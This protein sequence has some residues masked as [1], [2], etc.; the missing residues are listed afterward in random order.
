MFGQDFDVKLLSCL[1]GHGIHACGQLSQM[2]HFGG[3]LGTAEFAV[4]VP[5]IN[6]LG[7]LAPPLTLDVLAH[8]MFD[9][10]QDAVA[11][12]RKTDNLAAGD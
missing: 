6:R 8:L 12:L 3:V 4:K 9:G 2:H 11:E 10:L 5:K 7:Q 1:L